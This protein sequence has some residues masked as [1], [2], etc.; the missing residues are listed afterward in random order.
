VLT[1]RRRVRLDIRYNGTFFWGFQSQAQVPTVC[2]ALNSCLSRACK[3]A[4]KVVGAGRTDRGVHAFGQVAHTD[5][6]VALSNDRISRILNQALN[7]QG[8][9]VSRVSSVD[10]RFH[11]RYSAC[12]RKLPLWLQGWVWPLKPYSWNQRRFKTALRIFKGQHDFTQFTVD[13]TAQPSRVRTVLSVA[14]SR[15][16]VSDPLKEIKQPVTLYRVRIRANGFLRNMVRM[17][18]AA[19]VEVAQGALGLSDLKAAVANQK[20]LPRRKMAPPQGLVLR[21]IYY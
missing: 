5:V 7:A 3:Q 9:C 14:L 20:P 10:S 2:D 21:R 4:I 12:T 13:L 11:A 17:L 19:A 16:S 18:V 6:P 1:Q 8:L 15:I